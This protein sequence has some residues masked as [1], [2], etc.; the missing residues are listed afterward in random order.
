MKIQ[1]MRIL[2]ITYAIAGL[3]FIAGCTGKDDIPVSKSPEMIGIANLLTLQPDSTTV[4][5]NNY[6]LH[7]GSIDSIIVDK[8]L[9][10]RISSDSTLLT[11][12]QEN[13]ALPRLSE[14][15]VWIDGFSYSILLE[16]SRKIWHQVLFD[17]KGKN[18][19]KVELAGE[20]TEWMTKR[21]PMK[22]KENVW[23]TNILLD[24]GKYQYL[25][26]A[27]GKPM[28]DPGNNETTENIY[29]KTFSLMRVG[30]VS[31]AGI[32]VLTTDK[33]EK[34]KVI[35]GIKNKT[36]ELF[37][38]WQNYRL[39]E[40]FISLDSSGL[41]ITIPGKARDLDRSFIRVWACNNS[42]SSNEIL[43]PLQEGK[44]LTD[45]A[46][47]TRNDK[48]TMVIYNLMIDRFRN[49]NP[50]NDAPLR[51]PSV[52]PKLNFQGGDLTGITDKIK[53]GYFSKLGINTLR[54]S[55]VY[56]NP[57]GAWME[58]K[59]PKHKSSG[60]HG[61]WP[62][63]LSHVDPR[64]GSSEEL[65]NLIKEAHSK[66]INVILDVIPNY[67]HENSA[68]YKDHPGWTTPL[69][70]Q[71]KKKNVQLW[72]D[73]PYTT[74]FEE[75]LP[76]LDLFQPAVATMSSDS[77]VA[78]LKN[79]E[80]DGIAFDAVKHVPDD[81]WRLLS[82]KIQSQVLNT[83]NRNL[84][85][86]GET[87]GTRDLIK[88]YV[89]PGNLDGQTD[90]D[91]FFE[92]RR[93]FTRDAA[94]F[95]DLNYTLQE[96]FNHYGDHSLMCNPTG[97][98]DFSRFISVASGALVFGENDE[99]AGWT[100]NVEVKDSAGYAKLASLLAFNLTI[101][102]IPVVLYGDENAMAGAGFPDNVRRM[103]F[104]SLP[105]SGIKIKTVTDTLI[106]MRKQNLPLLYG[107]YKTLQVSD[108]IFVY[109][110]SYFDQLVIVVFNKDK[111]EKSV[112][113]EIPSRFTNPSLKSHFGALP[114]IE[115]QKVTLVMKGN[116][117]EV[118]TQ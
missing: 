59:D 54:L 74:W 43:I 67:V 87:Y 45:A 21:I 52:D 118:L 4:V 20:M 102:G 26:V 86:I 83:E 93:V 27:D 15:K 94:S 101:P 60:F 107:D 42:G 114:S 56:M 6:F 32:P 99:K 65:K 30:S 28:L 89:G 47:L 49:G 96:T 50:K 16:K 51:D 109:M 95:K 84:V 14:M 75:F 62:V 73:Y 2:S 71:E 48:E 23:E 79:Y 97:N 70:L 72:E 39:N 110:R 53:E 55:P 116:S 36:N 10:F 11:L 100:R 90:F 12:I 5:L 85:R 80:L 103:D 92:A 115:Q 63:M 108:K 81:Y 112:S 91:L 58:R 7:P 77:V 29:G 111:S 19:K 34:N 69:L 3:L 76:A 61:R 18:Y 35:I 40:K 113:F 78:W 13:R 64:F 46:N 38:F 1:S 117:F 44:V 105:L 57:A 66:E 24:P 104:D 25:I 88:K 31:P 98:T 68:I 33:A 17:P 41:T 37:V 8:N 22:L 82:G 106:H 9:S